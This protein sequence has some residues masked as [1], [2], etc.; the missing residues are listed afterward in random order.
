MTAEPLPL[1][2]LGI[3]RLGLVQ[4]ALGA[5]VVL[6]T[7]TLNRVMVVEYALPASLPGLLVTLHYAVQ[8]LRPRFGHGSDAGGRRTPWIIGGMAVLAAGGA[9]AGLAV[10]LMGENFAVGL[11]LSILAFLMIGVG[12]GAAG[13]SLLALLAARVAPGRRAPA[14]TLVWVMMVFGFV[15]TTAI[16][17]RLLDPFS[18]ERL[19]LVV[20]TA[21]AV[22]LLVA[23]L[24][25]QGLEGTRAAA[26]AAPQASFMVAL[27]AV[28]QEP[29]ARQFTVFVF[30]SMLAYS[31]QDLVL[32]PFAGSVFGLTLGESTR[33][34]S[35]QHG[36]VLLG[37]VLVALLAPR[38]GMPLRFWAV[39]GCLA[40][41]V[42]FAALV[43][44]A[45]LGPPWPLATSWFALGLANGV[46]AAAAIA[47]M[48]Q[49]AC[50]GG[51]GR[52]GMRLGLWGA[53]QGIAF[54]LGGLAGAVAADVALWLT[55]SAAAAYA[56]VFGVE[57]ALFLF[58][59]RLAM[60][61]QRGPATAHKS[62]PQEGLA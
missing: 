22:A 7:S 37:M 6:M 13:T 34:A 60:G 40:S 33:L 46:F 38:S 55:G 45:T 54:G 19:L 15:V 29:E 49:L 35:M 1:G 8:A 3:F 32:E 27:R 23:I 21:C 5:V 28:W 24:A 61:I 17:G 18:P 16:V 48:M 20:G 53:A 26:P 50:E 36:G 62:R 9:L 56:V 51:P 58:A 4:A 31:A 57:G 52:E 41:A 30:L 44:A 14:A 42:A 25:V 59:A 43:V 12:V 2:W 11:A 10:A 47:M 39:S